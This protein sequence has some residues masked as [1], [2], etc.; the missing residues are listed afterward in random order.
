MSLWAERFTEETD[1]LV[2]DFTF[3]IDVDKKLY[4]H[5]IAGSIAHVKM[6]SKV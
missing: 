4:P 5:D 1:E 3:S 2:K 6:L